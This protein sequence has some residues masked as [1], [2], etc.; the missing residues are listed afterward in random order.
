MA[1][2]GE[3]DPAGESLHPAQAVAVAQPP[4][5]PLLPNQEEPAN[6]NL[7]QN[8]AAGE[9]T[10]AVC[11]AFCFLVSRTCSCILYLRCNF[12]FS[13]KAFSF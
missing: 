10:L 1:D 12:N 5:P 7:R 9:V 6:P 11:S 4:P 8:A 3:Q 2:Q 13:F